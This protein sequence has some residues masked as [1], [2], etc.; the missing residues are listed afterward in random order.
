MQIEITTMKECHLDEVAAL[1][2]VSFSEPWSRQAFFDTINS[3]EYLYLVAKYQDKVVGYAG[4]YIAMDEGNITN[5]AVDTNY[6]RVGI[7]NEL[8][9]QLK[10]LLSERKIN[11]IFLE[12]RASNEAAQILYKNCGYEEVGIRKNFYSKPQ[13]NAIVMK[14]DISGE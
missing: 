7:G 4:C 3:E 1:E 9:V 14:L 2:S 8:M 6:R 11:C 12:V 5:I 10:R 13:E